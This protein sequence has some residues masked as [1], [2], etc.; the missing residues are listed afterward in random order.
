M[1]AAMRRAPLAS[2][3]R[4]ESRQVYRERE[5]LAELS[6]VAA[7]LQDVHPF[8]VPPGPVSVAVDRA[9]GL[10]VLGQEE[11]FHQQGQ[12]CRGHVVGIL[13]RPGEMA[14]A[15]Q[16]GRAEPRQLSLA[17]RDDPD[18]RQ[19]LQQPP[20]Q[21]CLAGD[22]PAGGPVAAVPHHLVVDV[23]GAEQAEQA[24]VSGRDQDGPLAGPAGA[25]DV[26]AQD[27]RV[28]HDRRRAQQ[29]VSRERA[30]GTGEPDG[31]D[32][33]VPVR[34]CDHAADEARDLLRRI[35]SVSHA[36]QAT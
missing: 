28:D 21:E 24:G 25:Q 4:G 30:L 14:D 10:G 1:A 22:R 35:E 6:G 27:I 29:D 3:L 12:H 2:P 17:D 36:V 8:P 23:P 34:A 32:R 26:V 13:V 18:Q 9:Q 5:S 31:R 7:G 19:V 20:A 16:L 33:T 11:S 15:R